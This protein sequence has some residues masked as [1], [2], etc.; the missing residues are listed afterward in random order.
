LPIDLSLRY[1]TF[2]TAAATIGR[3]DEGGRWRGFDR[4]GENLSPKD[5]HEDDSPRQE[6]LGERNA[7]LR[8]VIEPDDEAG[9]PACWAHLLDEE[10]H[11]PEDPD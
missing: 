3:Y 11:L 5:R 6:P 8:A 10:G 4:M 2:V 1:V 9:D 7:P